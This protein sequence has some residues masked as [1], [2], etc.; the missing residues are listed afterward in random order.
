NAIFSAKFAPI[1]VQILIDESQD[2]IMLRCIAFGMLLQKLID[3]IHYFFRP[4][5]VYLEVL[6]IFNELVHNIY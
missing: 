3:Q 5:C 2:Y 6:M 1:V 4:E